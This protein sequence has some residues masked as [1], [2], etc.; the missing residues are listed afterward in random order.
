MLRALQWEKGAAAAARLRALA[1]RALRPVAM[2]GMMVLLMRAELMLRASPM[3]AA[4]MAAGLAA[5][6]SPAAMVAGCLLGMLRLPLRESALLPALS[7]AAVMGAELLLPLLPWRRRW[8]RETRVS[9]TA[10]LAVLLPA[11]L[12]ARG[13]PLPSLQGFACAAMAATAAPFLL[14]ALSLRPGRTRLM[15]EERAGVTLLACGCL[16]GMGCALPPLAE[17]LAALAVM[18][19]S[20]AGAA[21]GALAGLALA[22]GGGSL[23][24]LASLSLCALA[25]GMKFCDRRW[26]RALALCAAAALAR[27]IAG[28]QALGVQWALCAAAVYLLLPERLVR[29]AESAASPPREESCR[30]ERVARE[31]TAETRRRLRALGD[32][33]EEMSAACAAPTDVPDEQA[34]ICE[35]RSRLCAGCGDYGDCWAGGENR[36]ARL[37]CRLIGEALDRVDA[38]PGMRVLFSDGEIPPDVLRACRRGRMIPDR[39]GLLMRDFAE[40]RRAEIKR[41]ATGQMMSVQFMQAREILYNLAERQGAPVAYRSARLDALRAALEAEGIDDCAVFA[42]GAEEAEVHISRPDAP[43]TRE[44]ARRAAAALARVLGGRFG[45][46][47][48]GDALCFT[49]R[50]RYRVET[51]ESCQSGVAGEACGDSHLVRMLGSA[52]MALMLSD[53]MGLGEAAADESRET[54]RL[55]WRFLEA[56]VSMQLALETV[57]RQMLERSGEDMFATVDLC[58]VDLN[59]GVAEMTKLA[60]CRTLILRGRELLRVEGGRLPLGI[61]EGVQPAVTRVR[62]RPGDLLVMGSDGVMEAGE[63]LMIERLVRAGAQKPP[64]Q[65]AGELVREASL[66]RADSRRDDLTCICARLCDGKSARREAAG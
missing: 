49:Q 55:L 18:L 43:W 34:L 50:P 17:A 35:M 58:L 47:L 46:S 63:A 45:L 23:L 61:L 53:G 44:E 7:C 1:R 8:A 54:L 22:A 28:A 32:V 30:A 14:A 51:G 15:P 40:K 52:R 27:W 10:G 12:W 24:K 31:V 41:C 42:C 59:T 6:E 33:F 64:E 57:N 60:A 26:Q 4:L 65:L 66:R 39:L 37:L 13:A 29:W 56:G 16:A 2:A 21:V 38:P 3:A 11:L 19:F 5:G 48:R 36:G 25:A 62:L 9:L 20:G